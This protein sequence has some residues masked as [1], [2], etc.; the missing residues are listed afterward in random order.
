MA[1][2]VE[3]GCTHVVLEVSSQAMITNRVDDIKFDIAGFTNFS[4]DHI[5]KY[6][7]HSLD[8]YFDA[9]VSLLTKVPKVVINWDDEKVRECYNIL[10]GKEIHDT[11]IIK[12]SENINE[13]HLPYVYVREEEIILTEKKT[14][15]MANIDKVKKE[16]TLKLPGKFNIYNSLMAIAITEILGVDKDNI[17][18]GL[19]DT[20]VLRKIRTGSK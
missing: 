4:E 3:E 16:I 8:E 2:L 9:K 10:N 1:D 6:E 18:E 14:R 11:G 19:S 17:V 20:K 15:Y 12:E 5:S 7:H 13:T